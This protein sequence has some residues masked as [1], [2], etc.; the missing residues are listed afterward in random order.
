V[1]S[2]ID[3]HADNLLAT[4][5]LTQQML[6]ETETS[7]LDSE[8]FINHLRS[9][10]SVKI[11]ILFREGVNG[12]IH[13]SMRSK[14]DT[15]VSTLAQRHGGGGHR[16]A[17]AFRTQGTMEGVRSQLISEATEVLRRTF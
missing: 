13:V 3:F 9:V 6:K 10:Q 16:N 15:D 17:A 1:L 11:A 8:G 5:S 12:T 14:G 7:P 2:T 4:A